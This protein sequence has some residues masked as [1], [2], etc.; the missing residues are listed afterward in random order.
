MP[1]GALLGSVGVKAIGV[2]GTIAVCGVLL[3][4]SLVVVLGVTWAKLPVKMRELAG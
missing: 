1:V 4:I 2:A 3:A